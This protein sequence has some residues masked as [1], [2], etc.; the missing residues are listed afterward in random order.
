[1]EEEEDIYPQEQQVTIED[2]SESL[3]AGGSFSP[4]QW[5]YEQLCLALPLRSLCEKDCQPPSI[6]APSD[7]LIDS[8]WQSLAKLGKA[9]D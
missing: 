9:I 2:L 7:T 1:M 6:S 4:N 8:R 3:F 5:L